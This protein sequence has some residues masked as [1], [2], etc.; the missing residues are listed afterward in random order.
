MLLSNATFKNMLPNSLTGIDG[1]D[2]QLLP[3]FIAAY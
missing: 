3:S 2:R 1:H